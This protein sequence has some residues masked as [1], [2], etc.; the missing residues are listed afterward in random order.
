MSAHQINVNPLK[1]TLGF[2]KILEWFASISAFATCGGFKGKTEIQVY[3]PSKV[4]GKKTVTATFGYP[5]RLN[6]AS[7]RSPLNVSV[8]V[9]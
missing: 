2:T 5:F 1:E 9:K 7:F 3:C 8:R 6:Q 4:G